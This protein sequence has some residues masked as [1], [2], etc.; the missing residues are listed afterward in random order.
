MP[1]RAKYERASYPQSSV[2][3]RGQQRHPPQPAYQPPRPPPQFQPARPPQPA[4]QAPRLPPSQPAYQPPH[5]PLPAYQP[6]HPPPPPQKPT[7]GQPG[8]PPCH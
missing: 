8:L 3:M 1:G 2:R 4:Y 7:C 6:P 5:P